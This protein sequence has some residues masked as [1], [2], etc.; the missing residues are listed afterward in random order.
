MRQETTEANDYSRVSTIGRKPNR[1][2]FIGG[3][4][5]G[6]WQCY[7]SDDR[8]LPQ[9]VIWL[10]HRGLGQSEIGTES[11]SSSGKLSLLGVALYGMEHLGSL[12]FYRY[13]G[14]IACDCFQKL[15]CGMNAGGAMKK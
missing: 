8:Q 11:E 14:S 6:H 1:I 12:P 4:V 15:V 2:E 9:D 3:P 13:V 7:D 10:T 5:D